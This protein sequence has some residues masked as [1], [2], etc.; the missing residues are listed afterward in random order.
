MTRIE[1]LD[2]RIGIIAP[3]S[4]RTGPDEKR[5]VTAPDREKRRLG[6]SEVIMERRILPDIVGV[7]EEEIQLD[8]N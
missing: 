4:L 2:D 8:I 1:K 3:V 6:S 7:A 5:V